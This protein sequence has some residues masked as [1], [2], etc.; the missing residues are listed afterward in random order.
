MQEMYAPISLEAEVTLNFYAQKC[1]LNIRSSIKYPWPT[2]LIDTSVLGCIKHPIGSWP[3]N[4]IIL[5]VLGSRRHEWILASRTLRSRSRNTCI[6][7]KRF[8]KKVEE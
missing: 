6:H 1:R 4:P 2:L 5:L 7:T 3:S 8:M